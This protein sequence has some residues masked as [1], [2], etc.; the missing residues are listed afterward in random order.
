MVTQ[1]LCN[2]AQKHRLEGLWTGKMGKLPLSS[3]E[4]RCPIRDDVYLSANPLTAKTAGAMI[5]VISEPA[6]VR[7]SA[8]EW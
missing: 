3:F 7:V 6:G 2:L 4:L 5:L 1:S 8:N